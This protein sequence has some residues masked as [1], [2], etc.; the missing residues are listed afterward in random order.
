[1]I[2]YW[3][4]VLSFLLSAFSY[5]NGL[6]FPLTL[7][8]LDFFP[9]RRWHPAEGLAKAGKLCL[10]KIPFLVISA[11]FI[12]LTFHGRVQA[13]GIW[14][15]PKSLDDFDLLS[16]L[17]QGFY[18]WGHYVWKFWL[19][20]NVSPLYMTL[21]SFKPFALPFIASACLVVF[22][23]IVVICKRRQ[24]PLLLSAWLCYLTLLIPVLG[25]TEHPHF[26]SDRYGFIV[27]IIWSILL[28]AA[29]IKVFPKG[30]SFAVAAAAAILMVCGWMSFHQT[31]VWQ[32][33]V[34]MYRRVV[35]SAPQNGRG[36]SRLHMLKSASMRMPWT[37]TLTL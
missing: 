33:S 20:I 1:L 35:K 31:E 9:L 32:D 12:G 22:L 19:P 16:R 14:T 13:G 30:R 28:A 27:G 11:L 17:M 25:F 29:M 23:T 26:P 3:A 7:L 18:I 36:A 24:A 15:E 37:A 6:T 34:S 10:E 21:V 2:Y 4:S 5:P 8:V